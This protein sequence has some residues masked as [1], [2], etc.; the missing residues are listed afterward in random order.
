MA[1]L[2]FAIAGVE[3]ERYAA[4]PSLL[5]K[6]RVA[7]LPAGSAVQ[8]VMLSCQVRIEA[9]RRRYSAAEQERLGELFGEAHRFAESLHSML[10]THTSLQVPAFESERMV[11]F[12]VACSFDLDVAAVK[13]FYGLEDGEVPLSF[14]FSGTVFTRDAEDGFLQ[15]NPIPWSKEAGYRLPVR[16]WREAIDLYYPKSAWLRLDR[17]VFDE[18]YRHK[19]RNGFTSFEE[20]LRSLLSAQIGE[21]V[22]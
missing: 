18:I 14:L 17:D 19:R 9:A 20:T 22:T 12:P 13:Y 21:T 15:M 16:V 2:S 10:W 11:D 3:A 7:S 1:D 4:A 6:L 5:F 8:N